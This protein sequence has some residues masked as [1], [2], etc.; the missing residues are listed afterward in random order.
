MAQKNV[1]EIIF[2]TSASMGWAVDKNDNTSRLDIARYA[3][4]EL[5]EDIVLPSSFVFRIQY[6][7]NC[8]TYLA[9]VN[10]IYSIKAEG[11]TPLFRAIGN[12]LEY[13]LKFDKNYKKSIVILSDGEDTCRTIHYISEKE[14]VKFM[15]KNPTLRDVKI[16]ILKI[17]EVSHQAEKEYNYL[18]KKT[19]GKKYLVDLKN[20]KKAV[21]GIKKDLY[22]ILNRGKIKSFFYGFLKFIKMPIFMLIFLFLLIGIYDFFKYTK[23]FKFQ[24][25]ELD[26][27]NE[28]PIYNEYIFESNLSKKVLIYNYKN[29]KIIILENF[30]LGK[31]E[32]DKNSAIFLND[33][34][35]N[36]IGIKITKGEIYGHSDL[37]PLKYYNSQDCIKEGIDT[38]KY[39][40]MCLAFDRALQVKKNFPKIMDKMIIRYDNDF[41][42]N[43]NNKELNG[44]LWKVMNI[45]ENIIN[46]MNELN[47]S[48]GYNP[49]TIR[50][51]FKE[52]NINLKEYD[53]RFAPFRSVVI[54][55]Y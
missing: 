36:K 42:I 43:K 3:F 38:K 6:F 28:K 49:F 13:L 34:F 4:K 46:I 21:N 1:M 5:M 7:Y 25:V 27:K 31:S 16:Y 12:S 39:P 11:A 10:D 32:L 55:V 51:R 44:T 18:V 23:L 33:I 40:N 2:D 17:G 53:K 22:S 35:T 19:E 15:K 30:A 54:R 41:F 14:I 8:D 50:R 52:N 48:K 29:S 26:I 20:Y 24:K 45:E 9:K 37:I 47:I